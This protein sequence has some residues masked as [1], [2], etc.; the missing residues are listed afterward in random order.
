MS[1]EKKRSAL[2]T[3]LDAQARSTG[4]VLAKEKKVRIKIPEDHKNPMNRVVPVCVNGYLYYINR[5]ETV[6]VPETG[7][8]ILSQAQYI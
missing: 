8:D 5:G 6:E 2:D 4:A 3:D 7:A 1:N